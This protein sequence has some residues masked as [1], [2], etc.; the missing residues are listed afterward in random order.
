MLA[1][2]SLI[3]DNFAD[4]RDTPAQRMTL[5]TVVDRTQYGVSWNAPN[6]SGGDYVADDVKVGKLTSFPR[7]VK[8]KSRHYR[9]G[10]VGQYRGA[11]W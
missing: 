1:L 4:G 5:E 9:C 10:C 8:L 6:Q 11:P 7:S 3:F 2:R